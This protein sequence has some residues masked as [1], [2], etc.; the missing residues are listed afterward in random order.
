MLESVEN[1]RR[2]EEDKMSPEQQREKTAGTQD[3]IF[4]RGTGGYIFTSN[5][6]QGLAP[7]HTLHFNKEGEGRPWVPCPQHSQ[8]LLQV[9][10]SIRPPLG[11][12]GDTTVS[13]D[14]G[15]LG[16]NF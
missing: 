10:D 14:S 1:Y 12:H 11:T 16:R 5:T 4:H 7:V 15:S 6:I 13:A 8:Q 2:A 9:C 3:H